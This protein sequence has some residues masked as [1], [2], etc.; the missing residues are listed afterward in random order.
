MTNIPS[1][2]QWKIYRELELELM[3]SLSAFMLL[4][5]AIG[6]YKAYA[7]LQSGFSFRTTGSS[8]KSGVNL[9]RICLGNSHNNELTMLV[10]APAVNCDCDA[11]LVFSII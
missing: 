5:G 3:V 11:L 9:I 7:T 8:N 2:C 10:M 4:L 1:Q 6:S